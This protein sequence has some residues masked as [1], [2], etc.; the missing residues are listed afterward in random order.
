MRQQADN[1]NEELRSQYIQNRTHLQDSKEFW[2]VSEGFKMNTQAH[3][4]DALY[5]P[6]YFKYNVAPM[7]GS[8]TSSPS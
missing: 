8:S 6:Y 5:N 1:E 2:N 4:N 7:I 3:A